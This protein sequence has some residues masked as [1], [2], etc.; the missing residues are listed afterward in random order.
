MQ[1][2]AIAKY[3]KQLKCPSAAQELEK[4]HGG[5][6]NLRGGVACS[7]KKVDSVREL[8]SSDFQDN[9]KSDKLQH[10]EGFL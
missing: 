5:S 6:R 1:Q 10:A 4:L 7:C 9:P 8:V 3:W 2:R